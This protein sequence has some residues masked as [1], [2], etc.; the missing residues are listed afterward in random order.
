MSPKRG[1]CS[2]RVEKRRKKKRGVQDQSASHLFFL[3]AIEGL[4]PPGFPD[5]IIF[6]FSLPL[7][8]TREIV[9]LQFDTVPPGNPEKGVERVEKKRAVLT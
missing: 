4:V 2:K 9:A 8:C 7:F 6:T 3:V 1:C 5:S